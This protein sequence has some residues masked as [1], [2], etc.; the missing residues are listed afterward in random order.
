MTFG[1]SWFGLRAPLLLLDYWVSVFKN[2][3][4]VRPGQDWK[5]L[6]IDYV[7]V[8]G[9]GMNYSSQ[10]YL[11]RSGKFDIC[12]TWLSCLVGSTWRSWLWDHLL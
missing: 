12:N 8:D 5:Y 2:D 3:S 9:T 1:S 6:F 10:R 7:H 4:A 11:I